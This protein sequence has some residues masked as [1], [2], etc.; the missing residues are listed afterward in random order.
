MNLAIEMI[1]IEKR[2]PRVVA[3][4]GASLTVAE[5]EIHALVGENGAGKST[6]MKILYGMYAPD[7][8]TVRVMGKEMKSFSPATSIAAG[9]GMVHQH[10]MLVPTLTVA[11]NVVL[12]MEPRLGPWFDTAQAEHEVAEMST[13]FGLAVEPRAKV[14]TLPVGVQQRVEILKV[15]ARGA[16]VL[17]LD[18]PT[19]VLTPG[20]IE[21]LY[22]TLAKLKAE[23]RTVVLITHKLKEVKAASDRLTVLRRGATAGTAV[24]A[25]VTEEKIAE[26][27]VGRA[28]LMK[29]EKKSAKPADVVLSLKGLQAPGVGPVTFD[30]RA[31]EIVGIAGVEGNGQSELLEC[32]SGLR[33]A[34][35]GSVSLG[36][37]DLSRAAPAGWFKAGLAIIPEDR[38]KR[39]LVGEFT[40]AENLVLGRHREVKFVKRGFVRAGARDAEAATLVKKFDVRPADAS[41]EAQSLSGGNQQKAIVARELSRQ[42]RLLIAAHPTRGVD[43]GAIEFIHKAIVSERDRGAA[44]LLVS[45]ELSEVLALADRVLVMFGGQIAGELKA[46]EATEKKVGV[47]MAGVRA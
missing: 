41:V 23:G 3:N 46:S 19:A 1:G 24:T 21:E 30:V 32:L 34:K 14:E 45:S 20:E 36:G 7:A 9:I 11:E 44:V 16:K 31:G 26:M 17:I 22:A 38:Q 37:I 28:V 15:L 29:V 13:R 18:E 12:G 35:A 10:F 33:A 47:L 25:D 43:I 39:G 2:F 27:M 42:P 8:G 6:L 5:G 4:S 40:V